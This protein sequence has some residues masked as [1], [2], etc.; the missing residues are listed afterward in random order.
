MT[1]TID[2]K[3]LNKNNIN[4]WGICPVAPVVT[5]S[6][7]TLKQS[8]YHI[9]TAYSLHGKASHLTKTLKCIPPSH[10]LDLVSWKEQLINKIRWSVPGSFKVSMLFA[11]I[12]EKTTW[13]M[14]LNR[15]HHL[16]INVLIGFMKVVCIDILS[17]HCHLEE[18]HSPWCFVHS[19]HQD[20]STAEMLPRSPQSISPL[21]EKLREKLAPSRHLSAGQRNAAVTNGSIRARSMALICTCDENRSRRG[22]HIYVHTTTVSTFLPIKMAKPVTIG[23]GPKK[24]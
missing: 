15:D 14:L 11:H 8:K 21:L 17:R 19:C 3:S 6:Y 24:H 7:V 5:F 20:T 1:L 18:L 4:I 10:P 9:Y 16:D 2:Y 13:I 23:L 22:C 12:L